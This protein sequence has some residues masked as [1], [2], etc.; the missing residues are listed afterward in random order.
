MQSAT[1]SLAVPP[2]SLLGLAATADNSWRPTWDDLV[3]EYPGYDQFGI[4]PSWVVDGPM[5]G[6]K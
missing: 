3:G 4:Q 6:E 5:S 2:A 1:S